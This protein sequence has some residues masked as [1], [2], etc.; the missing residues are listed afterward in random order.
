ML[1]IT[2]TKEYAEIIFSNTPYWKSVDGNFSLPCI[3]KINEKLFQTDKLFVT[4]IETDSL[5]KYV[6]IV[7]HSHI[8]QFT[9]LIELA[10]DEPDLPSGIL[11]LA[12][13]GDNFKGYR[14]RNWIS[15]AGNIHLS[16]YL[17]PNQIV[18]HFH[19]GFT[20]LSAI[21]VIEALDKVIGLEEKASIKWV[22]DIFINDGKVAGVLTQTQTLGKEVTDL[23][24]GIGVNVNEAPKLENDLVIKQATSLKAHVN[25][26]DYLDISLVF[27]NLLSSL[28]TNYKILLNQN[29]SKILDEYRGKSKIIGEKIV[30]YSDPVQGEPQIIN[31]GKVISIGDNLELFLEN[32]SDPVVRGRIFFE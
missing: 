31:K 30:V 19:I 12:N 8:S 24:I 28:T 10:Q 14:N 9:A 13:S 20:I 32:K 18:D 17:K 4:E 7:N 29:Y 22:N 23:F 3:K 6:F 16:A 1:I 15:L 11:C 21:S 5:W 2:D 26:S 25:N 27:S